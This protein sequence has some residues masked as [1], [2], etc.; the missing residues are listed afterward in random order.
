[1]VIL[2]RDRAIPVL[3]NV[4]AAAVTRTVRGLPTEVELGVE[5][6]VDKGCVVN[7]DNLITIAKRDLGRRRGELDS[8]ALRRLRAALIVA[9]DLR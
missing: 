7:C 4:V 8:V 6:G 5:H 1:V 3:A 9:L 2:T